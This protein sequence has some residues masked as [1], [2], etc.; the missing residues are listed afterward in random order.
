[1][2]CYNIFNGKWPATHMFLKNIYVLQNIHTCLCWLNNTGIMQ[3]GHS[4]FF[5]RNTAQ[6]LNKS[7]HRSE[8][9][10]A[11]PP[12][13]LHGLSRTP[14]Y[15]V[16]KLDSKHLGDY[17]FKEVINKIIGFYYL[18]HRFGIPIVREK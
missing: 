5:D 4:V 13:S 8:T 10:N 9:A 7:L 18:Y 11:R 1:M 12:A 17:S 14:S 16:Q 15:T 3:H 2:A 6:R